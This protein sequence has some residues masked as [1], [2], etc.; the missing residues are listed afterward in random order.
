MQQLIGINGFKT[1]GK[2]TTYKI[3]SEFRPNVA[4]AA[5]ADKLKVLAA[6]TLGYYG[7]EEELIAAMDDFKES[8]RV[9]VWEGGSYVAEVT[10]RQYLQNLGGEARNVF[11]D[12]FWIDQVLPNPAQYDLEDKSDRYDELLQL[13]YPDAETICVTDVRY[14]NE[15]QRVRHLGG[16]VLEI[17]RPGLASDG[18]SSEKPLPRDLVDYTIVNDGA[19]ADLTLSVSNFLRSI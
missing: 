15:A 13:R 17:V 8:S 6:L 11:G 10:G 4:R 2:D 19:L 12:T 5:F 9:E 1:S 16:I 3:I 18:H 7:T 14:P